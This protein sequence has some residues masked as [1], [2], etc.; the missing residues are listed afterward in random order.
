MTFVVARTSTWQ[1]HLL[2]KIQR[3]RR[4]TLLFRVSFRGLKF[5]GGGG[6]CA[7]AGAGCHGAA[8]AAAVAAAGAAAAAAA[9]RD[10]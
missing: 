4:C 6:G 3:E 5:R 1:V 7:G 10:S 2:T 8:G 9:I